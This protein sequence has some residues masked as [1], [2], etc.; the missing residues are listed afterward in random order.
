MQKSK[1]VLRGIF[2]GAGMMA[3]TAFVVEKS[4]S[5]KF[6]ESDLN[7]HYQKLSIIK[8]IVESSNLPHQD[9]VFISKSVDS[10]Q[11]EILT[12]VKAQ[13]AETPVKK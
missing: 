7:K 1:N 11:S 4:F 8:Q 12:Q 5:L 10:L 6:S 2:I 9:V 3:L 13:T